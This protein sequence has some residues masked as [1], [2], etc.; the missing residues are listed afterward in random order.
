MNVVAGSIPVRAVNDCFLP[1]I[2]CFAS[3]VSKHIYAMLRTSGDRGSQAQDPTM[4]AV[5]IDKRRF[6]RKLGAEGDR[7]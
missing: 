3:A 7:P 1:T 2:L 6:S 5:G 4:S